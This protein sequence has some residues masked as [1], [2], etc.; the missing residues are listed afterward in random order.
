MIK[1]SKR[2]MI[3]PIGKEEKM[4]NRSIFNEI[5]NY[6]YSMEGKKTGL[7]PY[8]REIVSEQ[9]TE[10]TLKGDKK[11]LMLGSNSYLGLT[12]HPDIKEA[13]IKA[14]KKYGTGCGGSRFLNGT[15]DIHEELEAELAQWVGKE[16]ALL[17][18]TGFQVNQGVIATVLG[19]RD[20]VIMDSFNHA[21]IIDGARLSMAQ[22][23]W[24]AHNDMKELEKILLDLPEDR[25]KL[26]ISDGI[27]SMEGDI[28][29]LPELVDIAEEFDA[30][31][32]IDDAHSFG[33]LG[34]CGS[35]TSD[36]F[37][38]SDKVD[39]IM[40]TFSKSLASIGGFIASDAQSIEFLKHHSRALIF[41][42]SMPP[43]SVA[44]VLEALKI[45]KKEPERI[46]KLWKN[47]EMMRQGLKS[48]GYDTGLS[49]TPIIPVHLGKIATLMITCKRIEELGLFVNPA[50]PPAV[51]P[52]DCLLRISL[53]ATHTESQISFALDVFEKVGRELGI[54]E[55]NP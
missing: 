29:R 35:G 4:R 47:T 36:H 48:L 17:F 49:E 9:G 51:P 6:T 24:Y 10:V 15:L 20:H 38:L 18:S 14:I 7:Y 41:S 43:A 42:A 13:A 19:G 25:G 8:F 31:V 30:A 46:E 26:I 5:D 33:V 32:M 23:S 11:L 27:F 52:N 50:V 12:N 44:A 16:A 3:W 54:I 53:M 34:K 21:S 22:I 45:I 28:V 55:D 2:N 37:G 40:G 1:R 39:F